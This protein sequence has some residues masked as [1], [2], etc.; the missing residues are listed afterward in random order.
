MRH[1]KKTPEDVLQD[2]SLIEDTEEPWPLDEVTEE[3]A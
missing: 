1:H 2:V 3:E